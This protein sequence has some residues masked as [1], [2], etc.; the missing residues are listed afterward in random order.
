MRIS[1]W[2]SD[3][4]S[5]DLSG[6]YGRNIRS[7]LSRSDG[8]VAARSVDGGAMTRRCCPSTIRIADGPPPHGF[9]AGRKIG[10][11]SHRERVCTYVL[12]SGVAVSLEKHTHLH[13]INRLTERPK[14]ATQK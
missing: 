12:F 5:S 3:V 14:N 1:D 10:S 2:S 11:A 4:C 6:G 7:S 9:A 13:T 8:E